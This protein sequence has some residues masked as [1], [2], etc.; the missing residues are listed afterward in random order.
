MQ[1]EEVRLEGQREVRDWRAKCE[2][3]E[4][5]L[6]RLWQEVKRAHDEEEESRRTQQVYM[7]RRNELLQ[8]GCAA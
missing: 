5:D 7:K 2:S 6:Q 1:V 8:V 3:L 4:G